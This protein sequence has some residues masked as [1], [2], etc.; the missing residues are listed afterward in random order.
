M[1]D[2][3][4]IWWC[5]RGGRGGS[6]APDRIAPMTRSS[7]GSCATSAADGG[8]ACSVYTDIYFSKVTAQNCVEGSMHADVGLYMWTD[9]VFTLW[10][11][12]PAV[13]VNKCPRSASMLSSW[14]TLDKL[15]TKS[16]AF[17][18]RQ[19]ADLLVPQMQACISNAFCIW[20]TQ[21]ATHLRA[22][23]HVQA[24]PL[25]L[26]CCWWYGHVSLALL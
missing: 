17:V 13:F 9:Q 11:N 16:A 7:R 19:V 14:Q 3:E 20:S 8:S 15:L 1:P 6:P 21:F 4:G 22:Q 12:K 18:G 2:A 26:L 5:I 25:L 24:L 23:L 10:A